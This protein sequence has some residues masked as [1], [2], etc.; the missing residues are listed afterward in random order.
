VLD[1]TTCAVDDVITAEVNP[2][3]V[4]DLALAAD[5]ALWLAD[6]GDNDRDRETVALH[7][8]T[9]NGEATLFRLVYP[10]GPHDAEA[11]LLDGSDVPY[12]VTK[13]TFGTAGVYRPAGALDAPGPTPLQR[14][15]SVRLGPTDT[16]GGPVGAAGSTLVTGAGMSGDGSVLALRTYTDAYLYAVPD[17][18]VVAALDRTPVR[19][20]LPGEPQGEAVAL[21]PD[22]TLLSGSEGGAPIRAVP[23]AT[24]LLDSAPDPPASEPA[25]PVADTSDAA[26]GDVTTGDDGLPPW[27]AAVLAAVVATVLVAL[28][29]RRRRT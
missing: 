20:P 1:P 12:I 10:D 28:G 4:E 27:P 21:A 22:G 17:G 18:D 9:R 11:L 25:P 29:T 23:E 13:A 6:T 8:L 24:A 7:R 14:V 15:G 3:D 26:Q 5:G 2:Y 19:V 16:V